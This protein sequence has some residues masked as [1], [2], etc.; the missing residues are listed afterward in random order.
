[1]RGSGKDQGE[2]TGR[3]AHHRKTI[4]INALRNSITDMQRRPKQALKISPGRGGTGWGICGGHQDAARGHT[5]GGSGG[6][7]QVLA[8]PWP[9][10]HAA[11]PPSF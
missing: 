2:S 8:I 6:S 7:G 5:V 11:W 10:L 4:K 3:Q 9:P 1:M